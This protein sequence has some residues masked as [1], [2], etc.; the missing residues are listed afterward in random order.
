[1]TRDAK[2]LYEELILDHGKRPRGEGGLAG[3]THEATVHNP[4]CGDRVTLRLRVED[5]E[6][7]N[8]VGPDVDSVAARQIRRLVDPPIAHERPAWRTG[9]TRPLERKTG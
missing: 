3:A 2:A 6:R 8:H 7:D 9:R 4:L 1:M 5:R